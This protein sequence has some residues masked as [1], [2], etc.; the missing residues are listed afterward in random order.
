M[1]LS[2]ILNIV[3]KYYLGEEK[4]E[5]VNILNK[6]NFLTELDHLLHDLDKNHKIIAAILKS[7]ANLTQDLVK[8]VG[9][10]NNQKH[11]EKIQILLTNFIAEFSN[12]IPKSLTLLFSEKGNDFALSEPTFTKNSKK[13]MGYIWTE[14]GSLEKLAKLLENKEYI[15]K[16]DDFKIL[17]GEVPVEKT[18]QFNPLK[19]YHLVRLLFML[20]FDGYFIKIASTPKGYFAFAEKK[21]VQY[22]GIKPTKNS[23]NNISS[24]IK[25]D[26]KKKGMKY[27]HITNEVKE[28]LCLI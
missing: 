9:K 4:V 20:H 17:F 2:L 12:K 14:K 1:E 3:D 23:F 8:T 21:F 18:I 27:K 6:Y 11:K 22:D 5:I 15:K 7:N 19:K 28:I 13:A 10:V 25:N 16:A 26:I 24:K